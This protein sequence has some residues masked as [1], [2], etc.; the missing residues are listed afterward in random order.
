MT[1]I[2]GKNSHAG[3]ICDISGIKSGHL[4]CFGRLSTDPKGV[5][6]SVSDRS[7]ARRYRRGVM[8]AEEGEAVMVYDEVTTEG[9]RISQG[10]NV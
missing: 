2:R 4:V 9:Y 6:V 7:S 1:D 3:N 10:S 8:H 5:R